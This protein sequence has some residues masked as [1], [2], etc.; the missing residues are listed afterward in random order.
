MKLKLDATPEELSE[1][2]NDLV[3]ALAKAVQPHAPDLADALHKAVLPQ[4]VPELKHKS[5]RQNHE[6]MQKKY[7]LM[8][9]RMNTEIAGLLETELTKSEVVSPD[10]TT[11]VVELEEA[12]LDKV[13][14]VL[15]QRG[16]RQE[17]FEEGGVLYGLSINQLREAAKAKGTTDGRD[18]KARG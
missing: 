3:D 8:L 12:A 10:Y 9:D 7:R 4:K 14:A 1:R 18:E 6:K 11:K 5:L 2:G 16:Y 13:K 15:M 17:D